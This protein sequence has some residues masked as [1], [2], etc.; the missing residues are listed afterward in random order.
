MCRFSAR[1]TAKIPARHNQEP[2][3]ATQF[4]AYKTTTGLAVARCKTCDTE[5]RPREMLPGQPFPANTSKT[6]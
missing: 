1:T 4:K 2:Q 6:R 5:V 3:F